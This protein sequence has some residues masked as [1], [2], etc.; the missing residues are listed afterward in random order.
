MFQSHWNE[1]VKEVIEIDQFSYPVYRAF[2][3][4][5]YTDSVDLPPEDAIGGFSL[6][7]CMSLQVLQ[8]IS[9]NTSMS[10]I[11]QFLHLFG[12]W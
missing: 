1:D 2:L 4:F 8:N 11:N 12:F 10:N 9:P 6:Q 5:L 7:W 3:Q